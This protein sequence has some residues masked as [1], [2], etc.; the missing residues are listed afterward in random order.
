MVIIFTSANRFAQ[1]DR[2]EVSLLLKLL[3]TLPVTHLSQQ[4]KVSFATSSFAMAFVLSSCKAQ[5]SN[6]QSHR[7][8]AF[9]RFLFLKKAGCN[10]HLRNQGCHHPPYLHLIP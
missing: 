8:I 1:L 6:H 9:T 5:N 10:S 7:Y 2:H 4:R 3:P